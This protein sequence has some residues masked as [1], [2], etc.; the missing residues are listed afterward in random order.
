LNFK[1][2]AG[3]KSFQWI[4]GFLQILVIPAGICEV[5]PRG[6]P[7]LETLYVKLHQPAKI[8]I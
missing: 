8:L 4:G 7:I 2:P 5:P 3:V 1:I 6:Q